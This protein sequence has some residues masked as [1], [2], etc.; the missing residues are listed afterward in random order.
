M[1]TIFT[2]PAILLFICATLAINSC[3]NEPNELPTA[4]F[5]L[6]LEQSSYFEGE[7]MDIAIAAK[8]FDGTIA[9][10]EILLNGASIAIINSMPYL[11][12]TMRSKISSPVIIILKWL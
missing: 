4:S 1:N 3:S 5:T 12:S 8:D 9:Q 10:V 6:P 2:I 7:L 11:F